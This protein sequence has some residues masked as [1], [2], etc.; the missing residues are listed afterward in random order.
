MLPLQEVVRDHA[1]AYDD[2][3]T[4]LWA[5]SEMM[6]PAKAQ[7]F[8]LDVIDTTKGRAIRGEAL[9][10]LAHVSDASV[11][12]RVLVAMGERDSLIR[13]RADDTM[14][15]LTGHLTGVGFDDSAAPEAI[16]AEAAKWRRWYQQNAEKVK[17]YLAQ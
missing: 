8:L 2:R 4:A 14:R 15:R 3:N 17:A 7:A 5:L 6:P 16:A 13:I 10:L 1:N 11:I 9:L 12:P